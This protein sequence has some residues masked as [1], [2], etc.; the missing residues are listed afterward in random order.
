MQ[1][2]LSGIALAF[3]L[4]EE[5]QG[6]GTGNREQGTGH[7]PNPKSQRPNDLITQRPHFA[8]KAK[9]VLQI[10]CPGAASQIDLWE[11]KPELEKRHG[12]PLPGLTGASS[13]QGG[14]G[15]IMRSPWGWKPRGQ[16]GKMLSELL[17]HLA[18]HADKMTF[19][20]L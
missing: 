2:G 17:P 3:L 1:T 10:F 4:A 13:F 8:P 12:Q 20:P 11:Y 6:Q 16:S 15:N 9:R 5:A 18:E 19:I 7:F 14:N